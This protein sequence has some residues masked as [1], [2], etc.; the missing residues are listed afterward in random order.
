M[1]YAC[2]LIIVTSQHILTLLDFLCV[3]NYEQWEITFNPKVRKA[4]QIHRPGVATCL[5]LD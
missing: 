5:L 2:I 3:S 4:K 1:S